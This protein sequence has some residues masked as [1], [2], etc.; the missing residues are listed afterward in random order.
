VIVIDTDPY[1]GTGAGGFWWD[2]A[3]PEVSE[4]RQVR[5]ARENYERQTALQRAD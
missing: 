2:V 5:D 4:R 3:V 1:P